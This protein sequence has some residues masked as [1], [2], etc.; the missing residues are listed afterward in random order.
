MATLAEKFVLGF[1][2]QQFI[3]SVKVKMDEIDYVAGVMIALKGY[4]IVADEVKL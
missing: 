2:F 4:I 1:A 3:R